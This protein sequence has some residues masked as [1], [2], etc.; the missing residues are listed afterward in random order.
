MRADV[1]ARAFLDQGVTFA[2]KGVERPF[3]LDLVPRIIDAAEWAKIEAGVAQRVRA[4][5][6]FLADVYGAGQVLR[7][8]RRAAPA[9]RHQRALPPGGGRASSRRTGSGCTSP[10]ST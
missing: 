1:L 9:G 5:E 6:A 8:R 7:R 4:L 2:L 3:P 10:A